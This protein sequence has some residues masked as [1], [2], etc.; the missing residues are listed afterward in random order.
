MLTD[1]QARLLFGANWAWEARRMVAQ[2]RVSHDLWA[3]DTAFLE[4]HE[5]LREGCPEFISWW[6]THDVRAIVAG[7]K[8]LNHRTK[9]RL[10]VEY[11]T[12]QANDDAALKLVIYTVEALDLGP[13][14]TARRK[15]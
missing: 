10:R 7:R 1:P 12:F 13:G 5:R 8:L 4:L 2:F 9:G 6:N 15:E 14:H 3:G 11:A